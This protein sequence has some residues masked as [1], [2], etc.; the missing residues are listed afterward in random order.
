VEGSTNGGNCKVGGGGPSIFEDCGQANVDDSVHQE[1]Q[2]EQARCME[3]W[4]LAAWTQAKVMLLT[5]HHAT[6]VCFRISVV[7][8]KVFHSL[9]SSA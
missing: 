1:M 9:K 4:T 3:G 5:P 2:F 7:A 8:T 6:A